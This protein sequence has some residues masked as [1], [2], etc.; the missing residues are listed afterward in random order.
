[1]RLHAAVPT[2]RTSVQTARGSALNM[3]RVRRPWRPDRW[4]RLL[5]A[6]S[7]EPGPLLGEETNEPFPQ[8]ASRCG[9]GGWSRPL[10]S[11]ASQLLARVVGRTGGV[12]HGSLPGTGKLEMGQ[13]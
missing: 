4:E 3:A 9:G 12:G 8:A 5:G 11:P 13:W 7:R 1:M 2:P 6:E 10:V